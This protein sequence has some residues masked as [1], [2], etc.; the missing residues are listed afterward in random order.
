MSAP[1]LVTEL[2]EALNVLLPSP[3]G[4]CSVCDRTMGR[5]ADW[6]KVPAIRDLLTKRATPE[7]VRKAD[8]APEMYEVLEDWLLDHDNGLGPSVDRLRD[9]LATKVEGKP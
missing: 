3:M 5:H 4:R 1:G 8:A 9:L 7:A 2:V 6:C